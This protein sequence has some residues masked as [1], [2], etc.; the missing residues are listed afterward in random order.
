MI[1][2]L[3]VRFQ[4]LIPQSALYVGTVTAF[5]ADGTSTITLSSGGTIIAQGQDVAIGLKA[6]VQDE[7]VQGEAPS[8][9]VFNV[10]V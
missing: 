7:R 3:F 6:F 9:T 4:R 5:N 8:L 1:K 10:D 2:N